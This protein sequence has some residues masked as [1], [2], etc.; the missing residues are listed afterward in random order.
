LTDFSIIL[1]FS[2]T[3]IARKLT[4][5]EAMKTDWNET[6][7]FDDEET[8]LAPSGPESFSSPMKG[9]IRAKTF[10]REVQPVA[11]QLQTTKKP[12]E[13]SDECRMAI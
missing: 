7:R 4:Q 10:S 12:A 13:S 6:F 5:T 8:E 2:D 9:K 3:Q 1:L 11:Y